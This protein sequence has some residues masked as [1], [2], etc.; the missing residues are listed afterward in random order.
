MVLSVFFQ[1][2]FFQSVSCL[3]VLLLHHTII[4]SLEIAYNSPFSI[5]NPEIDHFQLDCFLATWSSINSDG[6]LQRPSNL[7]ILHQFLNWSF[8]QFLT[9]LYF[10]FFCWKSGMKISLLFATV[11]IVKLGPYLK[12]C[13]CC[14]FMHVQ[15]FISIVSFLASIIYF[16]ILFNELPK[17]IVL[18]QSPSS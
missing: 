1:N 15:L 12:I 3:P 5:P 16:N 18:W 11:L 7:A 10:S 8:F 14:V 2:G 13:M 4:T 17:C 9:N 6:V